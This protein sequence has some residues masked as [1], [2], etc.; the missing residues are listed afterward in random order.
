MKQKNIKEIIWIN[1][2]AWDTAWIIILL[3]L[4]FRG[5]PF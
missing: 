5:V 2:L 4:L 3:T 1:L